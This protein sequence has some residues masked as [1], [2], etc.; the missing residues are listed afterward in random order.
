M[1]WSHQGACIILGLFMLPYLLAS[2]EADPTAA[3]RLSVIQ[4]SAALAQLQRG[5]RQATRGAVWLGATT[6]SVLPLHEVE[7]SASKTA[8]NAIYRGYQV[9]QA[10][11][12]GPAMALTSQEGANVA[13]MAKAILTATAPAAQTATRTVGA[14][15]DVVLPNPPPA[16]TFDDTEVPIPDFSGQG[17]NY[18]PGTNNAAHAEEVADES[19]AGVEG[20][21]VDE[22]DSAIGARVGPSQSGSQ[23]ITGQPSPSGQI[24]PFQ[25]FEFGVAPVQ[26]SAM[27][28][29]RSRPQPPT[30]LKQ[31]A[32]AIPTPIDKSTSPE[33]AVSN[34]PAPS[35]A[36]ALGQPGLMS[37]P[38]INAAAPKADMMEA[39]RGWEAP[40]M[41]PL[42][43]QTFRE[44]RKQG[45]VAEGSATESPLSVS[46]AAASFAGKPIQVSA[47]GPKSSGLFPINSPQELYNLSD[48]ELLGVFEQ[49]VA[50]IPSQLPGGNGTVAF[51]NDT[52]T[53]VNS[54]GP[55]P[56]GLPLNGARVPDEFANL[57]AHQVWR[58]KAFVTDPTTGE[59]RMWNV[60]F[61]DGNTEILV[62]AKVDVRTLEDGQPG[63]FVDYAGP[64]R[65]GFFYH[66]GADEFRRVGPSVW[67]GRGYLGASLNN[68]TTPKQASPIVQPLINAAAGLINTTGQVTSNMASQTDRR[69]TDTYPA[70]GYLPFYLWFAI[71]CQ[72]KE[73][74][75][76]HYAPGADDLTMFL[77]SAIGLEPAPLPKDFGNAPKAAKTER[78][79][80]TA[81]PIPSGWEK[82]LH[83]LVDQMT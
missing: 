78:E 51:C 82:T 18:S 64:A 39:Q 45:A 71:G 67:L 22:S 23:A 11:G 46:P 65:E 72:N 68:D 14:L 70:A 52:V 5:A 1:M 37:L 32:S 15:A 38:K 56:P 76:L 53:L 62:H 80:A 69:G 54:V 2:N 41:G 24:F 29:Q 31:S 9:A 17:L 12:A 27:Y 83:P 50:D 48:K 30:A 4:P 47:A 59:T 16:I 66:L 10:L 73:I 26:V 7:Q 36:E 33:T 61:A 57:I 74:P 3:D 8:S 42:P 75:A 6:A 25:N 19:Q 63:V 58:A 43:L 81:A 21:E 28:P 49:G 79:A 44:A 40:S 60:L 34:G 35:S 13:R 55:L 77:T 20:A